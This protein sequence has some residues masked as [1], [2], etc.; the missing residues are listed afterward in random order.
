MNE[1]AVRDDIAFIRRIMEQG[2]CHAVTWG[3]DTLVW[4]IA[5]AIGYFGTY[6]RVRGL[7]TIDTVWLWIACIVLPWAYSLRR[8]LHDW[9][10]PASPMA[11]ALKMLW[12]ACGIFLTILGFAVIFTGE[13]SG[14]WMNAVPAGVIGIGF[15]VSSFLCDFAWMRWIALIAWAGELALFLLRTDPAALLLAGGLMLVLLAVP[16]LLLMRSRP[17]AGA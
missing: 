7:W 13:P 5:I 1:D 9:K 8:L 14:W 10:A 2:R 4:G 15:F 17:Q 3:P 6:A 16:G 12:F 11:V